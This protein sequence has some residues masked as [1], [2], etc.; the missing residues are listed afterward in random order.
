MGGMGMLGICVELEAGDNETI[1]HEARTSHM[2]SYM[3]PR[4]MHARF[5]VMWIW[6]VGAKDRATREGEK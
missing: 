2:I 1:V 3:R 4:E 6:Y 5:G